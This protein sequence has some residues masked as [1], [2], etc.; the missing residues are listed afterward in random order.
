MCVHIAYVCLVPTE[1]TGVPDL[2]KLGLQTDVSHTVV[3]GN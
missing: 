1:V 3:A 2:L